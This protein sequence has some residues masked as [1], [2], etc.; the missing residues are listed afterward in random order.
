[1]DTEATT[2]AET[3]TKRFM[4]GLPGAQEVT[5]TGEFDAEVVENDPRG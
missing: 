3:A 5:R 1:M 4:Q 2:H